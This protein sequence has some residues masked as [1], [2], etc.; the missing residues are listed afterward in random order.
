[1][2]PRAALD[3]STG[4]IHL[5]WLENRSGVGALVWA[6]C[7]PGGG[8]CGAS[9]AVS[10]RPFAAF[11]FARHAPDWLGEYSVLVVDPARRALHAAWTQPVEE[12]GEAVSRILY[13]RRSLD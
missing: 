6:R 12:D 3:P 9:E 8:S 5:T 13:A 10:D 7:E 1:M 2:A 4:A 11:R